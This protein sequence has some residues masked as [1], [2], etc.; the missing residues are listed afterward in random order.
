MEKEPSYR[1]VLKKKIYDENNQLRI[2]WI[3]ED[4]ITFVQDRLG[5]DLRYAIDPEKI[6]NDLGW[7]PETTFREGIVKT[8]YWY[9]DN[10]IWVEQVAER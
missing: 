10:Q 2:D 8:I 9:L 4:L 7:K 5:H 3:N 1:S 6:A